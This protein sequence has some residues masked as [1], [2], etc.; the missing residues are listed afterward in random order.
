MVNRW[1]PPGSNMLK[2]AEPDMKTTFTAAL[3]FRLRSPIFRASDA[4]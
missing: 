4:R 2:N 1:F 3:M